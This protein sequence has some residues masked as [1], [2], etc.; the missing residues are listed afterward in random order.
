[1]ES[2]PWR[3][4]A[5]GVARDVVTASN[6][7]GGF[8]Q[9]NVRQYSHRTAVAETSDEGMQRRIAI[10]QQAEIREIENIRRKIGDGISEQEVAV[11][12]LEVLSQKIGIIL[13][14]DR[15]LS[16]QEAGERFGEP[17]E[18]M[19]KMRQRDGIR[20]PIIA[21][22]LANRDLQCRRLAHSG[23]GAVQKGVFVQTPG[24]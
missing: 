17:K 15:W 19:K 3:G 23:E 24:A 12:L 22:A 8:V 6:R 5:D 10:A 18:A 20:K 16:A 13:L 14:M 7:A 4:V 2:N 1:V 21:E 9:F 11:R